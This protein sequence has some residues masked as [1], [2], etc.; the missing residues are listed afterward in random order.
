L[1]FSKTLLLGK[2]ID[3]K[4]N[5]ADRETFDI[6]YGGGIDDLKTSKNYKDK[7]DMPTE[8]NINKLKELSV[9]C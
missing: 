3:S 7:P 5:I 4:C 1:E 2:V 9:D 8:R 6:Y